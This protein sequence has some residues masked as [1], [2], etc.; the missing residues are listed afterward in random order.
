MRQSSVD[1]GKHWAKQRALRVSPSRFVRKESGW[2]G[3]FSRPYP[4]KFSCFLGRKDV[5]FGATYFSKVTVSNA[6]ISWNEVRDRATKF[7]REWAGATSER[8]EKHTF[9]NEIFEVFGIRRRSVATFEEPVCRQF[10]AGAMLRGSDV[11]HRR[12]NLVP[13]VP[14]DVTDQFSRSPLPL[15]SCAVGTPSFRE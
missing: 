13:N 9:W 14:V 11:L 10:D 12:I 5:F 6:S 1:R 7:A 3:P 15:L 2:M 8:A 4:P